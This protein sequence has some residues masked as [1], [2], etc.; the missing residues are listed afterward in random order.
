MIRRFSLYGFLKNQR[1]YEPF[2][3]LFFLEKGLSFTQIGFLI[4]FRELFIN[5]FEIPSGALADLYGRRRCMMFSFLSYI[6]AFT[7]FGLGQC[8]WHFF[9]PMFFFAIGEAFRTGTHKAMIFTWLRL[10]GRI[11]EKT[12]VYGYTRSWSKFGSACSIILATG[13]VMFLNNYTTVFYLSIIPYVLGLANFM[14][15]PEELDC[16][17]DT[18]IGLKDIMHHLWESITTSFRIRRLRRLI[19]ESMAFEGVFKAVSDYI[20]PILKHIAL[21]LPVFVTLEETRR[22]AIIV[23]AVYFVLHLASAYASR[24]SYMLAEFA[25]G[26]ERGSHIL[27][28]AV[29]LIYIALVPLLFFEWY[30]LAVVGFVG[31]YL[32]QNYW[33]PIQISRFDAF[34]TETSGATVLSIESQAKAVSTMLVAPLLGWTVDL[35]MANGIGGGFWPVGS[36]AALITLLVLATTRTRN[37]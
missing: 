20:Q 6:L 7:M 33:K 13:F 37:R 16:R 8:Y 19:L 9:F 14:T 24:K 10:Q 32:I 17:I 4:A 25:G 18:R 21:L 12:K 15:Y 36:L 28:V 11:N 31:L 2:I 26:E 23:G 1:Y 34:A 3:I 29:F 30:Y 22:T 35:V 5:L 27:W